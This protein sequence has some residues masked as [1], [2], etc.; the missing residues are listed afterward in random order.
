M[1]A[2]VETGDHVTAHYDPMIAKVVAYGATRDEARTRL[3]AAL[4]DAALMGVR[5][6]AAFLTRLLEDACFAKGEAD[7]GYIERHLATICGKAWAPGALDIAI[8]AAILVT[9]PHDGL[10]TGWNSRGAQFFS[11]EIALRR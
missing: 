8:A 2:G 11:P 5:T 6:N 9:A 4:R 7:T 10:L 1:D 3:A